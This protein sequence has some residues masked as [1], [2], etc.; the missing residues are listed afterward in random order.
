LL[1]TSIPVAV[2]LKPFQ[3]SRAGPAWVNK[4]TDTGT[5]AHTEFLDQ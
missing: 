2:L 1:V 5:I 4:A 3:A